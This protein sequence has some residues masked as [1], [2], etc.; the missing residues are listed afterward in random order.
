[1]ITAAGKAAIRKVQNGVTT[2]VAETAFKVSANTNYRIRLE[3]ISSALRFYVNGKLLV[4]GSDGSYAH[5]QYGV[6]SS[7]AAS[8]FDNVAVVCP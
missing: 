2:T 4:E 6:I 5:G 8:Q 1:V 7:D 3:A